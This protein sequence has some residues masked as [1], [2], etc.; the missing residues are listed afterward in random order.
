MNRN[1]DI[2]QECDDRIEQCGE[3]IKGHEAA[4]EEI[5]NSLDAISK[6]LNESQALSL[7]IAA[8]E[9]IRRT[10][11]EIAAIKGKIEAFDM[12]EAARARRQF[13][14]KYLAEKRREADMESEV[15]DIISKKVN[16]STSA[17]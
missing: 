1:R 9:R 4:L 7:T 11:R 13:D 15:R 14:T 12:E 2:L 17:D 8:N 10:R 6:E 5:R 16:L 3:E